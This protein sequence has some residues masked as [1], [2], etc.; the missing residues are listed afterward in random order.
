MRI[1]SVEALGKGFS[2]SAS[3]SSRAVSATRLSMAMSLPITAFMARSLS[4]D[5]RRA[6]AHQ[7]AA[8]VVLV[9]FAEH[10]PAFFERLEH[11]AQPAGAQQHALVDIRGLEPVRRRGLAQGGSTLYSAGSARTPPSPLGVLEDH[12]A[13]AEE[14]RDEAHSG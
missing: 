6:Q 3:A 10:E 1:S 4:S 2:A 7:R 8:A 13:Q 9:V 11:F 14:S 12:V 5:A